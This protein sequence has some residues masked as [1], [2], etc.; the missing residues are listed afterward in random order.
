MKD[1]EELAEMVKNELNLSY[2]AQSVK[3]VEGF[4]ERQRNHFDAQERKGLINSIASFLGQCIIKNYGGRWQFDQETQ[5][6]CIALDDENKVFPFQK[7]TKQFDNGLEDSVYSFYTI[8]P[9][10]FKI[11]R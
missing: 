2:D 3:F 10:I 6:V 1:F 4:I 9:L 5:S 11:D 8:I 7:V